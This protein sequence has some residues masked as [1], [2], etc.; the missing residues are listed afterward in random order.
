MSSVLHICPPPPWCGHI[1]RIE[2]LLNVKERDTANCNE[3]AKQTN[4]YSPSFVKRAKRYSC[5]NPISIVV[6]SHSSEI[7]KLNAVKFVTNIFIVKIQIQLLWKDKSEP[8]ALVVETLMRFRLG[9]CMDRPNSEQK[10][11]DQNYSKMSRGDH[12]YSKKWK[13][14][15]TI[16]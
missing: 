16:F 5:K 2:Q 3:E 14:N 13:T 1:C 10:C 15:F 7:I 11:F 12:Q 6:K 8:K 9:R 4:F